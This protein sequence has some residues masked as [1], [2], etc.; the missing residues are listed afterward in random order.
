MLSIDLAVF[1]ALNAGV[2]T[3]PVV[4]ALA[5]AISQ[6][7]PTAAGA[8]LAVLLAVGNPQQRRAVLLALAA[9]LLAWAGVHLV[10]LY[11]AAPRPAQL[12]LGIQWIDHAARAS[13]PSMHAAGAFALAAGLT[14]GHMPRTAAAAWLLAVAMAWSR[15]CLGVHFPSDVLAG[16]L[17]GALGAGLADGLWTASRKLNWRGRFSAYWSRQARP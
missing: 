4:V 14:L 13:F 10:R 3:P 7:L 16:A 11:V 9:M 2:T 17:T 1:Q 12:G 6:W 8:G 5:R 15:V